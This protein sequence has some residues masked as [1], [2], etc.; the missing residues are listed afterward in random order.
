MQAVSMVGGRI[1]HLHQ[2]QVVVPKMD[3]SLGILMSVSSDNGPPY[4]SQDF[5]D[6][7][8]YLGF[9]HERKT[10]LNP[11]ANAEAERFM[12]VLRKLYQKSKLRGSTFKQEVTDLFAPTERHLIASL[13]LLRQI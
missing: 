8:K 12:R 3:H 10:P 1:S 6:F 13:K 7:I 9:R 11:Q 4:K 5:R 2:C